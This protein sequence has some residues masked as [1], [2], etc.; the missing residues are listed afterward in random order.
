VTITRG[1]PYLLRINVS[2]RGKRATTIVQVGFE[3][4]GGVWN[5]NVN[6]TGEQRIIPILRLSE[7]GAVRVLQPGEVT[8]YESAP[9]VALH[10]IDSPLRPFAIDSHGRLTWGR[11]HPL[12]R[13]FYDAGWRPVNVGTILAEPSERPLYVAPVAPIWQ[14]WKPRA[15][16]GS[17]RRKS[18]FGTQRWRRKAMRVTFTPADN[19]EFSSKDSPLAPADR[20][21]HGTDTL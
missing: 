6:G 17:W 4:S 18:D 3:V 9:K 21:E 12:L 15:L 10:Y 2:N 19:N 5:A 11:A 14:I 13:W 20:G 16:R 8:S 1:G 7:D